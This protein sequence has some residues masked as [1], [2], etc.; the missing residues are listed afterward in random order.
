MQTSIITSAFSDKLV[1]T[2]SAGNCNFSTSSWYTNLLFTIRALINMILLSGLKLPFLFLKKALYLQFL[3]QIPLIFCGTLCYIFG[4]HPEI[5]IYHHRHCQHIKGTSDNQRK[6]QQHHGTC[7]QKLIEPVISISSPH[8]P[9]QFFSHDNLH[10][11]TCP[12]T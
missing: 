7:H 1:S 2:L 8:K 11:C 12:C 4:K 9:L 10:F 6:N 5:G 3:L